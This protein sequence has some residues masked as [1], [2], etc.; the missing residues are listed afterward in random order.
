M[1]DT[2]VGRET[3]QGR[4]TLERMAGTMPVHAPIYPEP[5]FYYRNMELLAF[6]YETDLDAALDVLPDCLQL[7]LPATATI[8][9]LDAPI[10]TL[11]A[12]QEAFLG[13]GATFE[14]SRCSTSS[15]TC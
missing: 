5:P 6:T 9:V 8:A 11:G 10:C 2:V 4:M 12:Y 1:T 7:Q 3:R 15:T 14:G 13:I